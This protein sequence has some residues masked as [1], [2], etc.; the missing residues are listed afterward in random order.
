MISRRTIAWSAALS[1]AFF[2][3]C[4]TPPPL[5]QTDLSK[6]G[7][8]THH[9]QALWRPPGAESTEIAGELLVAAGPDNQS[10]VQFSK[11]PFPIV[12]AKKFG[13]RWQIEFVPR[14]RTVKGGD[15]GAARF[16]WPHLADI[17]LREQSVP[18]PWMRRDSRNAQWSF[19]NPVSGETLEGYL[20][21]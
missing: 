11:T 17:L 12:I 6:P 19:S 21:P 9:G 15:R 20:A 7:W 3:S 2:A 10:F 4:Q 13:E 1:L 18:A 16:L 14:R 8:K 5:P